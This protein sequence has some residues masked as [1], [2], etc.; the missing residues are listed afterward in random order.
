MLN[1]KQFRLQMAAAG[2]F[3]APVLIFFVGCHAAATGHNLEG[4][5]LVQQGQ[6]GPALQRFQEA[7]IRDPSNADG[8][9]NM[10]ATYHRMGEQSGHREHL[11]QAETLYYQCL[12]K[13]PNHV[14]CRRG[15]AVLLAKTNRRD[16]AFSMLKTW[17]ASNPSSADARVELARLH[18]ELGDQETAK[19]QLDEALA[20][21]PGNPRV[22]SARGFM[23]EREG[24][25]IQA[26]ANYQ[27][28]YQMDSFQPGVAARI[29]SLRQS[30]NSLLAPP[31]SGDTRTVNAGNSASPF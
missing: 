27:R 26:L 3:C 12:E 7:V 25:P 19:R 29:A 6:Y 15:L 20:L 31:A 14:D 1:S 30:T 23:R 17:A 18:F 24:D 2:V 5:R 10:A 9:Y 8:Y 13:D 21:D 11:T 4:K 16:Q 22:W 28:S